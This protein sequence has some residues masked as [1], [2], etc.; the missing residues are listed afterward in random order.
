MEYIALSYRF[1]KENKMTETIY[2]LPPPLPCSCPVVLHVNLCNF[3]PMVL[4]PIPFCISII[5]SILSKREMPKKSKLKAIILFVVLIIVC[6]G[7]TSGAQ[8]CDLTCRSVTGPVH[9]RIL[10]H[11]V[12][13]KTFGYKI[14]QLASN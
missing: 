8:L 14:S 12:I 7:C 1:V 5:M 11:S 4:R 6:I 2:N 3:S 10:D 9:T 13:L